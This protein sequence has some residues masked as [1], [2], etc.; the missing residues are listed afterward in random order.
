MLFAYCRWKRTSFLVGLFVKVSESEE[1]L[2]HTLR[3]RRHTIQDA[4][5][6]MRIRLLDTSKLKHKYNLQ[7]ESADQ[8]GDEDGADDR[9]ASS[10]PKLPRAYVASKKRH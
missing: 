8:S 7:L 5:R 9:S 6:E 3:L 1:S 4:L 2:H 10:S